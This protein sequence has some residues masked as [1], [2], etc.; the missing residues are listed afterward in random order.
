MF[1]SSQVE[2]DFMTGAL[3]FVDGE[4][5]LWAA[6]ALARGR[7]VC[8]NNIRGCRQGIPANPPM[9]LPS[10][11]IVVNRA[12][13]AAIVEKVEP[14]YWPELYSDAYEEAIETLDG[15]ELDIRAGLRTL[16]SSEDG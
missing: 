6:E 5:R 14:R 7:A 10:F 4:Q 13:T 15:I 3:D 11:R 12:R 8:S 2:R 1:L 16:S 9:L